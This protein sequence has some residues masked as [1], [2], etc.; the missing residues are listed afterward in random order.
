MS[1]LSGTDDC[2]DGP[3]GF[4][5]RWWFASC[6]MFARPK[7]T[8]FVVILLCL[9]HLVYSLTMKIWKFTKS[10]ICCWFSFEFLNHCTI[11]ASGI[12]SIFGQCQT[13]SWLH[14]NPFFHLLFLILI[15]M[16][17]FHCRILGY[18][19]KSVQESNELCNFHEIQVW[20]MSIQVSKHLFGSFLCEAKGGT[21]DLF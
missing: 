14:C 20:S 19:P 16:S 15:I 12:E 9:K 21:L 5:F 4:I 13:K 2:C 10:L 11:F 1:F 3:C 17:K 7:L 8:K 18:L 6:T